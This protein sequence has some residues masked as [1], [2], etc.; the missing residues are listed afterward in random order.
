VTVGKKK[1]KR[2][3]TPPQ[4]GRNEPPVFILSS[5]GWAQRPVL[6]VRLQ[7][8]KNRVK[9]KGK[10]RKAYKADRSLSQKK[11]ALKRVDFIAERGEM[12]GGSTILKDP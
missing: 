3:D 8:E 2:E 7:K 4:R 12:K 11:Q 1:P 10:K 6:R 5:W 9:W